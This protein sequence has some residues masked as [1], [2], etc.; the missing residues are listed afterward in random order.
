MANTQR[1]R[2]KTVTTVAAQDAR[3]LDALKQA[4]QEA[5]RI[6][7]TNSLPFIA[8]RKKAWAVPK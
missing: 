2:K 6:A 4:S 1:S 8:G 5:K 3:L 7:V